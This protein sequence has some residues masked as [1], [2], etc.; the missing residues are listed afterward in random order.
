M[1]GTPRVE[2][3]DVTVMRQGNKLLDIA[4][5]GVHS[6]EILAV[7]GPNGAGKSTLV[8][9]MSLLL[10]PDK[11]QVKVAGQLVTKANE[12]AAR[13]KLACVFQ[14]PHLLDRTVRANVELGMRFRGVPPEE[15]KKRADRW[16]AKLGLERLA[17]RRAKTLSGG[18]A[19]RVNLARAL[20]LGPE[21]LLLDEPLGGLDAPTRHTLLDDLGP[22]IRQGAGSGVLVTHDRRVALA[23]GDRV[24][25]IF[26]GQLRQL[27]P[28]EEVFSRPIDEATAN[29]VGVE[30]LIPA[31]AKG[32]EVKI[33]GLPPLK[34]IPGK[35]GPVTI[36]LRA[37][38]VRLG[39]P[40]NQTSTED[41]NNNKLKG[42]ITKIVRRGV[43]FAAEVDV[44]IK[45]LARL[46]RSDL[47]ILGLEPGQEV[48]VWIR[49][50][51]LHRVGR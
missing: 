47:S 14:S 5:L 44:G 36:C 50:T 42:T 19:Q 25:V 43:G 33:E 12:H 23:L 22:L 40:S 49:P 32:T 1:T 24:A 17:Q 21:V 51:A 46:T 38:E 3:T 28:P 7:V 15:R 41:D 27:G 6:S 18:E 2:I 29:F 35:E 31:K 39:E 16:I 30:N 48:T 10:R 13:K 9:V 26:D 8:R 20:V 37:E 4:A 45:L 11:G 34:A